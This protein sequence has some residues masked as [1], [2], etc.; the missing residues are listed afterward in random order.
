MK[1]WYIEICARKVFCRS[2]GKKGT[3]P[4][5]FLHGERFSSQDWED[6]GVLERL[7]SAGWHALAVDLPGYGRSE[8][9]EFS[10]AEWLALLCDCL[11]LDK[12]VLVAPSMSGRYAFPFIGEHPARLAGFVAVAPT[13]IPEKGSLVAGTNFPLLAVWGEND[14]VV[15]RKNA[16]I[17]LEQASAGELIVIPDAKHPAYLDNPELFSSL[18]AD[19]LKSCLDWF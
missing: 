17:L 1:S 12:I 13:G 19:F 7:G 2:A 8:A 9:G 5:V 18:M 3:P 4:V 15:P 6:I 11:G 10:E 16:E 14:R